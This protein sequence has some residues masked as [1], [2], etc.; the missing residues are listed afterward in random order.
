MRYRKKTGKTVLKL[1][2]KR[3]VVEPGQ[4]VDVEPGQIPV[5]FLDTFEALDPEPPLPEELPPPPEAELDLVRL[6]ARRGA[7]AKYN[8][9]NRTSRKKLNSKPLELQEAQELAGA[10]EE[11]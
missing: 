3:V 9:V 8:V 1:G 7:A 2:G 5:A 11:R 4:V 6:P 10:T